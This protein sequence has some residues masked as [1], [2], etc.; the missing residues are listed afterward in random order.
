VKLPPDT[1]VMA[2]TSSSR[3]PLGIGVSRSSWSTPYAS[4]DA[5]VPPP[6]NARIITT[7]PIGW[8]IAVCVG[9]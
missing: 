7:S 8:R 5:R 2:S 9:R 4:A 1:D 6:E 3:R